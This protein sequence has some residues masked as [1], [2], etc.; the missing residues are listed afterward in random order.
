VVINDHLYTRTFSLVAG[1]MT[2]QSGKN[3][4]K[5]DK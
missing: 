5:T 4:K 3:I 2:M 1:R